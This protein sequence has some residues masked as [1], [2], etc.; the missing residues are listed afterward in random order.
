MA[1]PELIFPKSYLKSLLSYP[2]NVLSFPTAMED[3]LQAEYTLKSLHPTIVHNQWHTLPAKAMSVRAHRFVASCAEEI[4]VALKDYF[5]LDQTQWS[6]VP[7]MATMS[8]LAVRS[9]SRYVLGVPL[10]TSK[11]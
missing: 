3:N 10:C 5:G 8:K 11:H 1:K 9:S 2:D 7:V 6:S 4:S